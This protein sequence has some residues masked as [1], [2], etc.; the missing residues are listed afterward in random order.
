M[1]G[2]GAFRVLM[3]TRLNNEHYY[4]LKLLQSS[5]RSR[6]CQTCDTSC[7]CLRLGFKAGFKELRPEPKLLNHGLCK[8]VRS[9]KNN[10]SFFKSLFEKIV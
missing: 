2:I 8:I 5:L 7:Q 3:R 1:V 6:R 9:V 10:D 4:L